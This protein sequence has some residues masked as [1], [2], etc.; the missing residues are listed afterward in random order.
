MADT[1]ISSKT[2]LIDRQP[3]VL[4]SALGDLS[5]LVKNMPEDKRAT[6][7]ATEDSISANMQGFNFG[8]RVVDREPFSRVTFCQMDGTPI[9]FRIDACFDSVDDPS[10]PDADCKTNFHLELEAQLG[11]MLKMMLG[12][13]LQ[14]VLDKLTDTIAAAAE[15]RTTDISSMSSFI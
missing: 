5:A 2:V 10:R 3:V 9:D 6:I 12:S 8:M 13:K 1:R 15:G 7:T 4:Y 11:G 14:G